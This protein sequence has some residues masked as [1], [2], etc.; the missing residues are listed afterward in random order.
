[1]TPKHKKHAI[2]F[3]A[4]LLIILLPGAAPAENCPSQAVSYWKLNENI[5]GL[6]VDYI[7]N[8]NGE[9]A[10]VCPNNEPDGMVERAKSFDG[11]ASGISVPAHADYDWAANASFSIEMWIYRD[12]SAV[13]TGGE[14]MVGRVD[15]GSFMQWRIGITTDRK[16]A[17]RLVATNGTGSA[18]G[19]TAVSSKTV[20]N[21]AWHHIVAVRDAAFDTNVLYVDG[22]LEDSVQSLTYDAGFGSADGPITLGWI[23]DSPEGRFRGTL[24]DVAIY[25]RALTEQEI[26]SHYYLARG[27]CNE[28][29]TAIRIMP[30]GDSITKDRLGLPDDRDNEIRVGY[31]QQLYDDLDAGGYWFD[32][33]GGEEDGDETLFDNDHGAWGGIKIENLYDILST[34]FNTKPLEE[35]QITN[36]PYLNY[37]PADIVLLHIGTNDVSDPSADFPSTEISQLNQVLNEIDLADLRTTV[38]LAKII[39]RPTGAQQN[40]IDRTITLNNQIDALA[41]TRILNGDKIIVVDMELDA[42]L[43]YRVDPDEPYTNG[44][45][46]DLLHPNPVG[47]PIMGNY[48]ASVLDTFL[49]RLEALVI[50]GQVGLT[51]SYQTP[52]TIRLSDLVVGGVDDSY[53]AGYTLTVSDGDNYSINGNEVIPDDRFSGSLTVPASISNGVRQSNTYNL[54]VEV[55]TEGGSSGGGGGGGGCFIGSMA[56]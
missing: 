9:C 24:D 22:E 20:A 38:L 13:N 46:R 16:A 26:K 7:G 45:F 4:C 19:L 28:L 3:A 36:G 49:P 31:R 53:P 50:V 33:V 11:A 51:T 21:G 41:N 14:V 40:F 30:M 18:S 52:I 12:A 23:D 44:D 32:L 37:Y 5:A 54:S 42:G 10:D 1:M 48:W 55:R 29:D 2:T 47:Y 34:G 35:G 25:R 8:H 15:G 17:F 39:N 6:Y 27:Y 56:F 43:D